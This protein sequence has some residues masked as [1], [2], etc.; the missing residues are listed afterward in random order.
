MCAYVYVRA[1]VLVLRYVITFVLV[2]LFKREVYMFVSRSAGGTTATIK[3]MVLASVFREKNTKNA[4][5]RE[6]TT[7]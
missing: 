3:N 2:L 7:T 5:K 6:R 4:K 1:C